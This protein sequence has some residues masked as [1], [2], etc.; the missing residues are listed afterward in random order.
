MIIG[1]H[2]CIKSIPSVLVFGEFTPSREPFV[3]NHF[4]V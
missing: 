4:I 1:G 3:D 2:Y